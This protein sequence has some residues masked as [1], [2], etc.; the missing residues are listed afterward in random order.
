MRCVDENDLSDRQTRKLK[1]DILITS[2]EPSCWEKRVRI[3]WTRTFPGRR[4][5]LSRR[6]GPGAHHLYN[7]VEL[8]VSLS[9]DLFAAVKDF[10]LK[11]LEPDDGA[12]RSA[13]L[14]RVWGNF[15]LSSILSATAKL[16]VTTSPTGIRL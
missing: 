9:E 12:R 10:G 14:T 3:H 13:G 5:P 2:L 7:I 11:R 1:V 6:R 15:G 4:Q 16:R 8:I